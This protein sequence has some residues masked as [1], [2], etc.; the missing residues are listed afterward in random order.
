MQFK[1][2]S[3]PAMGD[4]EA[5]EQFNRLL[6]SHRPVSVQGGVGAEWLAVRL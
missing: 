6:R 3:M 5:E 2:F 4:D 1:L